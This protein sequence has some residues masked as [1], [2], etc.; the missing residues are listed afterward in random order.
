MEQIIETAKKYDIEKLILFGS[1][2]RGDHHDKSDYDIAI[3]GLDSDEYKKAFFRA[4]RKE[5]SLFQW[6]VV[7]R[8]DF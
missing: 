2:A 8:V 3:I 4:L 5:L 6:R 7:H 1:R